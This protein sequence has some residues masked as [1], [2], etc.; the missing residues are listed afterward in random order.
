VWEL[1]VEEF[2]VEEFDGGD[3]SVIKLFKFFVGLFE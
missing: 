3:N 1:D 2:D